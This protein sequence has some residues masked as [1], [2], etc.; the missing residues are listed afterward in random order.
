M[1][2]DEVIGYF[3]DAW[4][5]VVE[6]GLEDDIDTNFVRAGVGYFRLIQGDVVAGQEIAEAVLASPVA[7]V[8]GPWSSRAF[9]AWPGRVF[10]GTMLLERVSW[11]DR[12]RARILHY[13]F[14]SRN[15]Q[16]LSFPGSRGRR[17]VIARSSSSPR[18]C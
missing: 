18:R 12:A 8:T 14:P 7:P 10:A 3:L 4:R 15:W 16:E 11:H 2:D 17:A 6:A 13:L 9:L 5:V 1:V